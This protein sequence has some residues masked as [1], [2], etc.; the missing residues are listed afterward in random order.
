MKRCASDN[1]YYNTKIYSAGCRFAFRSKIE[2]TK[3]I[4]ANSQDTFNIEYDGKRYTIGEGASKYTISYNKAGSLLHKLCTL[5]ALARFT[6]ESEIFKLVVGLPINLYS[7]QKEKFAEYIKTPDYVPITYNG[8]RK[9]IHIKECIVFP[10]GAGALYANRPENYKNRV[11]AVLDIGGLT[12]DGCIFNNLNLL[13]D[14]IFTVNL[15]TIILYNKIRKE[16]NNLFS[17][18]LQEYE[19]PYIIRDGLNINGK[20]KEIDS[21]IQGILRSH[22]DEII[23]EMRKSN[24]PVES[25]R[26]IITGGG[27]LLLERPIKELIPNSIIGADPLYDN[28]IGFYNIAEMVYR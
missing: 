3:D 21:I 22:V 16:L 8:K 10:Q 2:E 26:V 5:T 7:A 4:M 18:N 15:G 6:E 28:C 24:W 9:Y 13:T 20:A 19:I 1:G 17:L 11:V 14:S 12:V 25:L 23:Q 27:V